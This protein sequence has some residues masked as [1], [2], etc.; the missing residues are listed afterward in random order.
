[1]ANDP[2]SLRMIEIHFR[3]YETASH[4]VKGKKVLDIACGA[5]YGSQMLHLAGA[6]TV[7]GVDVSSQTIEYAKQNYQTPSIEFICADAE[8]FEWSERFDVVASFETI[9]HLNH[10]SKFL[11]RIHNILAPDGILLLSVPLGETRHMD[12]Y[13]LHAFT[14]EQVFALL[15]KI[16]FSV[17]YYRCDQCFLTR[18]DLLR[19][20]KLY[21]ETA[22]SIRE[23]LFSRRGW[24]V[25]HDFILRGGFD[26]PQLLVTARKSNSSMVE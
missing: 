1:M 16:G 2:A 8:E 7:V 5:G 17:D 18:G 20:G 26:I 11:K 23:L 19:L 10:P 4:Y 21:P 13:H 3:R 14:Q 12:P 9:E 24:Q 6:T 25:I 15:E 22:P